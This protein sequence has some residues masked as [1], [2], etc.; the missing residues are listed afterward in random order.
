MLL[1]RLFPYIH[2][3]HDLWPPKSIG[4][5]L[6]QWLKMLTKFDKDAHVSLRLQM[7]RRKCLN[8]SEARAAIFVDGS[9]RTHRF[10]WWR[11]IF[12]YLL[13]INFLNS[14]QWLQ[15]KMW[16]VNDER[17]AEKFD[18]NTAL[19]PSGELKTYHCSFSLSY[20]QLVLQYC[21]T[22]ILKEFAKFQN[23]FTD[24]IIA[25]SN[26]NFR[27]HLVSKIWHWK[28]HSTC[29]PFRDPVAF[30]KWIHGY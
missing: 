24:R 2:R 17:T 29:T 30:M 16:R 5:I 22:P 8:Q 27:L 20:C 12:K 28:R 11:L 26:I 15:S 13:P 18:R 4:L 9:A 14:V 10:G 3:D 23:T 21:P 6:S 19:K 25:L 7:R 1:T